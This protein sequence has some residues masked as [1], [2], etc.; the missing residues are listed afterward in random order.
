M[1]SL[2]IILSVLAS[3]R[4]IAPFVDMNTECLT[5]IIG[6]GVYLLL[7]LFLGNLFRV[8][9][10]MNRYT[11]IREMFAIFLSTSSVFFIELSVAIFTEKIIYRY[12]LFLAYILMTFLSGYTKDEIAIVETGIRPG[13]KLYEELL[14]DK[15]KN[16]E[17]VYEKIFIGN[18]RG[19]D[20][21]QVEQFLASLD[22]SNAANTAKQIIAFANESNK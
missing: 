7:Y 11:G 18:I 19:F 17:Q 1:D 3:M 2:L 21:D 16:E 13:E 12:I 22:L 20:L 4:F 14:L 10:R 6:G 15:E 5:A 9:T 8:F